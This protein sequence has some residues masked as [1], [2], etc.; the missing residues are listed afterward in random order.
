MS[1]DN[2]DRHFAEL[3]EMTAAEHREQAARIVAYG[4]IDTHAGR[5]LEAVMHTN[6]AISKQLDE[7]A[8]ILNGAA[9]RGR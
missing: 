2:P 3:D 9:E 4:R 1:G 8:D 5:M 6:L 7:I